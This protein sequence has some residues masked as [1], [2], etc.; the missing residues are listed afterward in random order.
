M[1]RSLAKEGRHLVVGFA[2]G[3]IPSLPANLPLLKTGALI[4]VDYRYY[5]D[6][7]PLEAQRTRMAL[8]ESVAAGDLQP[9]A[10]TIFPL[11]RAGEALAATL[12]RDKAGKIV[13]V[14]G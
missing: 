1:F 11:E 9:P 5:Y 13:V 4:G 8:F 12:G 14:T 10:L 7:Y 6:T 3:S 2:A